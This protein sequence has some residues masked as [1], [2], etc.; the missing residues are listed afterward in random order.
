MPYVLNV[1]YLLL[2]L[3]LSPWLLYKA[4]T[5][6]KYHKGLVQK[7]LGS[8]F[9]RDGEAPCAWFHGVSVGEVHALA[10]LVKAFRERVPTWECV[11][12]SS[13]DTGL[14][15]ASKRFHD[16]PVFCWPLD[17]SWAVKRALKRV[18]PSL[19]VLMEGELWPNFTAAAAKR[20]VP[21][22]IANG[23]MSPRSFASYSRFRLLV[24]PMLARINL[25][26]VQTETYAYSYRALGVQ[27]DRIA[28]TGSVKYDGVMGHSANTSTVQLRTLLGVSSSELTIIAGSTQEPEEAIVLN[29]FKRLKVTEPR[30]RLILVPRQRDRFG[31][32][33]RLLECCGLQ[34][35]RRSQISQPLSD[36]QKII[37]VDTIGELS[38]LWGLADIAFVGGSLDGRRGGQNMIEPAAFGTAVLFGPYVWNFRDVAERLVA[39]DAAIQVRS[40]AELET[41]MASLLSEPE[42]RQA[43]GARARDL[44]HSQQGATQR[45]IDCL[46]RAIGMEPLTERAA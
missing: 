36:P 35:V 39:A 25:F 10:P 19:V 28:V 31:A 29:I 23:R 24:A 22:A 15:E 16:L 45:T 13:T 30:L 17:F 1:V 44:V 9:L 33:A 18:N 2:L 3:C 38:A 40:A 11:I 27:P 6:G 32:V 37:L 5:T 12:S 20:G 34:Y 14:E 42:R 46:L 26:A 43:M 8:S 7:L 4:L 41:A 21:L